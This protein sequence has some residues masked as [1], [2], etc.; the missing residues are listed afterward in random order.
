MYFIYDK[1]TSKPFYFNRKTNQI[2]G[3]TLT[4]LEATVDFTK[5]QTVSSQIDC[6]F[7]LDE[8]RKRC[9]IY[10]VE[11][12]NK[13]TGETTKVSSGTVVSTIT[14][15]VLA[16]AGSYDLSTS[17]FTA[18]N[19]YSLTADGNNVYE[20]VG[21]IPYE[22]ADAALGLPAGNRFIVRIKNSAIASRDSLP[23]GT[24]I[25]VTNTSAQGG[26]NS[27]DKSAAE[28]DGSVVS[29]VNVSGV[30][31]IEV[32]IKWDTDVV[33]YKFKFKNARLVK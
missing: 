4:S 9:G 25:Q 23:E 13:R 15:S 31:D 7:T 29:I 33:T 32:K 17:T 6:I 28:S 2:F 21:A 24:I 10:T 22:E 11:T 30:K 26:Y 1:T 12:Y 3:V 18:G 8:I 19:S 14:P 5:P 27:Y 20:V 16:E